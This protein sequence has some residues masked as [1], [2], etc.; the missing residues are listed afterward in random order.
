MSFLRRLADAFSSSDD[1]AEDTFPD[2]A[3]PDEERESQRVVWSANPAY[4][5]CT[6]PGCH[7]KAN[8]TVLDHDCCGRCHIGRQCLSR[9]INN[10]PGP[11]SF[12][13]DYWETALQPG[14]FGTCGEDRS[15][16]RDPI[17]G[18]R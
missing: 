10:Y 17:P 5:G 2:Y 1:E 6:H 4:V 3:V 13:H 15:A 16:H 14:S 12:H 7:K 9:A 11:G 18:M 8:S